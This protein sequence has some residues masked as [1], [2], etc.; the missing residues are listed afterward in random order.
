MGVSDPGA[1]AAPF[2]VGAGAAKAPR[3]CMVGLVCTLTVC[4]VWC[5][6]SPLKCAW[7]ACVCT[8]S[9]HSPLG[10]CES[11]ADKT[12]STRGSMQATQWYFEQQTELA[13]QLG[14]QT[15]MSLLCIEHQTPSTRGTL[16]TASQHHNE[17][18]HCSD[19]RCRMQ[20]IS[21]GH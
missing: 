11:S 9:S 15:T 10:A 4:M 2:T 21:H 8:V 17:E 13:F 1:L 16:H 18:M 14:N 12:M 20:Q 19:V 5:S 7:C 3:M 6:H